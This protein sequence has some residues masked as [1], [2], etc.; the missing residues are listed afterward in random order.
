METTIYLTVLL[1]DGKK[2]CTPKALSRHN[3]LYKCW[4]LSISCGVRE[5]LDSPP[6]AFW[7]LGDEEILCTKFNWKLTERIIRSHNRENHSS[8]ETCHRYPIH[9]RWETVSPGTLPRKRNQKLISHIGLRSKN[10][11]CCRKVGFWCLFFPAFLCLPSDNL[12]GFV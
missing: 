12:T 9:D 3:T 10:S 1:E 7:R 8:Y 11:F 4:L 5:I 6:L 2:M